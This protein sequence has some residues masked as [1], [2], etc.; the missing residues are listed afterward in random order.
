MWPVFNAFDG[1]FLWK[2]VGKVSGAHFIVFV[3]CMK[4]MYHTVTNVFL[5]QGVVLIFCGGEEKVRSKRVVGSPGVGVKYII[6]LEINPYGG[7][8]YAKMLHWI[9][10]VT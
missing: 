5:K 9:M 8:G 4:A 10:E 2:K 1:C 3:L 7:E 6:I